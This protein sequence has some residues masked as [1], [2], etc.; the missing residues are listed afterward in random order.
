MIPG[1]T[2]LLSTELAKLLIPCFAY[3]LSLPVTE[4][5]INANTVGVT[6]ALQHGKDMA[7]ALSLRS[8]RHKAKTYSPVAWL[9]KGKLNLT[10][11]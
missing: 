1:V 11:F 9:A 10:Y 7:W 4:L 8:Q 6:G 2:G 3:M 5:G